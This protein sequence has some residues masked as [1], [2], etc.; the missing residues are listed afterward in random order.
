MAQFN[1]SNIKKKFESKDAQDAAVMSPSGKQF[2]S[3]E[4]REGSNIEMRASVPGKKTI[5]D[6]EM[7]ALEPKEKSVLEG[8]RIR[9]EEENKFDKALRDYNDY[10]MKEDNSEELENAMLDKLLALKELKN[11][12]RQS[13][14][15]VR[16]DFRMQ[17]ESHDQKKAPAKRGLPESR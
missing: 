13:A 1:Y 15:A 8:H 2:K 17:N 5:K 4:M 9:T 6:P 7:D 16:H 12:T 14:D 10:A 3:K 11:R